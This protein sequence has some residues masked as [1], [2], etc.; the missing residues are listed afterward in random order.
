LAVSSRQIVAAYEWSYNESAN[1]KSLQTLGNMTEPHL[2]L[3]EPD[4]GRWLVGVLRLGAFLCFAGWSWVH[5]DW[6]APYGVLVWHD[7]TYELAGRLG[8]SWDDFV[9]TGSSDGWVQIWLGR[10]AWLYLACTV[11]TLTVQR[12]YWLQMTG[13]VC[14][15][16]ML[17]VLSYAK[18]S[19]AQRQLPM[20]VEHGGQM[21]MPLLLVMAIT[22]GA[23]HRITVATAMVALI[24]TFAGHGS[25]ALGL[26]PTPPNFYALTT[27]ILNVEYDT[28]K[29]LLRTVGAL[30]L[31][32]CIG[33]LIPWT[34]RGC[35]IYAVVWGFLTAIA[36]P[37]A[38]MSWSLYYWGADQYVHE[39][40]L[41]APHWVIPLYLFIVWGKS[42]PSEALTAARN[43]QSDSSPPALLPPVA[44]TFT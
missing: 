29:T 26:W 32:A 20:F 7:A 11:L 19:S 18:F 31:I 17:A 24:M 23:R 35:A 38:G 40:V 6:E 36:R 37:V 4:S 25:Y 21:L 2:T 5:Y 9:G 13:L 28:A 39:A 42:F 30:D 43:H 12:G 16:G 1:R 14:G 8:I 44:Q 33:I 3:N 27:I 10:I 15:A 34:R 22:L 41:R